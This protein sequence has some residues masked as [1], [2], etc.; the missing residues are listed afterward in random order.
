[1]YVAIYVRLL[2]VSGKKQ[3]KLPNIG[4]GSTP[5]NRPDN[6]WISANR[7]EISPGP[8]PGNF[9]AARS[10]PPPESEGDG[11]PTNEDS[12]RLNPRR[13]DRQQNPR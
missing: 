9:C 5:T 10:L 11:L 13:R 1:M 7:A 6:R 2:P 4:C 3:N 8:M 12:R